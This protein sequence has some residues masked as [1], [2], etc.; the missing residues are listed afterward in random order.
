MKIQRHWE[1]Q[2]S[3][4]PTR[5]IVPRRR[6]SSVFSPIPKPKK[7]RGK[8]V[9]P[10]FLGHDSGQEYSPT[11]VISSICSAIESW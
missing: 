5:I 1:A 7:V 3:G 11:V 6:Q 10:D 9:H 2:F 4:Q 8:A